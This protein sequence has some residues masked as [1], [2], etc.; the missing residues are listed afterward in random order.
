MTKLSIAALLAAIAGVGVLAFAPSTVL[1]GD[2]GA[3]CDSKDKSA[4]AKDTKEGKSEEKK[5]LDILGTAEA[6]G[7]FTT[8]AVAIK[9]AGLEE[10]LKGDGPFTVFAPTDE[11]FAKLPKET[12]ESLLKPENKDQLVAILTYHVVAG[13]VDSKA[14]VK[15]ED[16]E[17]VQ[18]E[19]V[20]IEV[21]DGKVVLNGESTVT[22]V[23]VGATNGVIHV[24]DT[25]ILPPSLTQKA[26]SN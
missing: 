14:V 2:C 15:L 7:S 20:K 26:A 9:A 18:G 3:K 8:L 12:L 21:K 5:K 22:T 23:D 13:K 1:A 10:T 25:V 16:A 19:K 4:S 17:T 11:A 24:I 6:A